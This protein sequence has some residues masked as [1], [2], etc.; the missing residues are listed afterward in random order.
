MKL[1]LLPASFPHFLRYLA[2]LNSVYPSM[3]HSNGISSV[4]PTLIPS[5]F[6][7]HSLLYIPTYGYVV[8]HLV[9]PELWTVPGPGP[10]QSD[11]FPPQGLTSLFLSL[12]LFLVLMLKV[13]GILEVLGI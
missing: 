3:P 2:E 8:A 6:L 5:I 10:V 1:I 11:S 12:E 13:Q 9:S 7:K 4:V